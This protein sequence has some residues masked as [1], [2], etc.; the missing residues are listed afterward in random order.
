MNVSI[1][2]TTE[3]GRL[4]YTFEPLQMQLTMDPTTNYI[5][6]ISTF[7]FKRYIYKTIILYS[8]INFSLS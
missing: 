4:L 8:T 7:E 2:N 1:G 5:G 3:N 6:G